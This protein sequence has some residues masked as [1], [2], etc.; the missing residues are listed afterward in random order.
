MLSL[1]GNLRPLTF[2]SYLAK[3]FSKTRAFTSGIKSLSVQ[4]KL[5]LYTKE[6]C[7]LCET[8][9]EQIEE[10]YPNQFIIEEVDITKN[11][12]ELFRKYKYDI[13]VF[14][15]NGEFLMMHRVDTKALDKLIADSN[16]E[17]QK[18]LD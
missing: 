17:Q 5:V 10:Q 2:S 3:K 13:P 16:Q 1:V 14:H 8:A 12:R 11:N 7:S 4:I 18:K 15:Y 9:K 6:D